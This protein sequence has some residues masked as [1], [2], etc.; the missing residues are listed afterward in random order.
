MSK[1]FSFFTD[2]P[3]FTVRLIAVAISEGTELA[4][5]RSGGYSIIDR[6]L[7]EA[8]RIIWRWS[9]AWYRKYQI[10]TLLRIFNLMR[11][12][13]FNPSVSEEGGK[14]PLAPRQAND[15]FQAEIGTASGSRVAGIE[16]S[17][18]PDAEVRSSSIFSGHRP[19]KAAGHQQ[20]PKVLG[21]YMRSQ[22]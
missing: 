21:V 11:C 3:P 9:G 20:L 8:M 1:T 15:R 5:S 13:F 18:R 2:S 7:C 16:C 14:P 12:S 6:R 4:A 10:I 22:K 17:Y 19:L